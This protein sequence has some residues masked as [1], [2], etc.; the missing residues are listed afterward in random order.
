MDR[1]VVI[2]PPFFSHARPMTVLASAL[3]AA[4]AEV[5][6]ACAPAFA[7]AA[8]EAGLEFTPL[9]VTRNAN[10]GIAETTIQEATEAARLREFLDST[11]QG[12]VPA[13]LTQ[14]R[15]RRADMLADPERVLEELSALEEELRPD[16]YVVDQL[17]YAATLALHCLGLP[18]ATYCPG[19]PSY[20]PAGAESHFGVPYA[21]PEAIRPAESDLAVLHSAAEDNDT[22]FSRLFAEF[23]RAHAPQRPSP[24]R[25]FALTS[26]HAVVLNYPALDW[27]PVPPAGPSRLFMGHCSSLAPSPPEPLTEPWAGELARLGA[28]GQP[29]VLVALGTFLSARDD[30]LTTVA[31]GVLHHTTASVIVA[32]GDRTAE[33]RRRTEG[34]SGRSERLLVVDTVPQTELLP[35]VGAMVHHGGNNSFTECL[36]AG[37][38]ALLLPFSSDQFAV[39]HDAERVGAGICLNPVTLT[40]QSV[41]KAVAGLLTDP[42]SGLARLNA[43][44]RARGPHWAASRLIDAMAERSP[45]S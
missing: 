38:P 12:A 19:H 26:P 39:A 25:A 8:E 37:V 22:A 18:Y 13:L 44:V 43:E 33:V 35:R 42:P 32:A 6:F 15:H 9:T 2:S 36:Q 7:Q 17:S 40:A 24:G 31:E 34:L 45:Q 27:L 5:W 4:G 1:I 30:I 23:A 3:R 20:L 41:G 28:S 21:W 16:W 10:T 29:V 14:A 11:R